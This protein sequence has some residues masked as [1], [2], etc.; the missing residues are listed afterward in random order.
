MTNSK[1]FLFTSLSPGLLHL[2]DINNSIVV[3][4]DVLRATST[5]ATALFNEAKC[6]IPVDNVAKCIE[7]G[8]QI[9]SSLQANVTGKLRKALNMAIRLLN[10]QKN[11][12]RE[13]HWYLR[14]PMVP[15]YCIWLL[16]K[17]QA[18]LLPDRSLT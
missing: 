18:I 10:T 12:F 7:L 3:I 11:L 15:S 4:I 9:D 14:Q 6:V 13:K 5:I 8:K 16:I 2:Y 1:P 17:V